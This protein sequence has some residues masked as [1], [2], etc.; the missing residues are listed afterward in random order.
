MAAVEKQASVGTRESCLGNI[1]PNGN[2]H[3]GFSADAAILPREAR[4]SSLSNEQE[5]GQI[6]LWYEDN[7]ASSIGRETAHAYAQHFQS[8]ARELLNERMASSPEKAFLK[9]YEQFYQK[10]LGPLVAGWAV[11]ALKTFQG[12]QREVDPQAKLWWLPRDAYPGMWAAKVLSPS[13]GLSPSVN[14]EAHVNRLNLGI[15]DEIDLATNQPVDKTPDDYR[16]VADYVRQRIGKSKTIVVADSFQYGYMVDALMKG[17]NSFI[18]Q[19]GNVGALWQN[20]SMPKEVSN[21]IVGKDVVLLPIGF[22]SHLCGGEFGDAVPS[23]LNYLAMSLGH[24]L[25]ASTSIKLY[26]EALADIMEA[27]ICSHNSA[28]TFSAMP[29]GQIVPEIKPTDPLAIEF[30]RAAQTGITLAASSYRE[31]LERSDWETFI[32]GQQNHLSHAISEFDKAK[33]GKKSDFVPVTAPALSKREELFAHVRQNPD[34]LGVS[35]LAPRVWKP[36]FLS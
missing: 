23:Y 21:G 11:M 17:N 29:D 34:W 10:V 18:A 8:G 9:T 26:L 14:E 31:V 5:L 12:I 25:L 28:R 19:A 20:G 16:Q 4:E 1:V 2:N 22:Y 30:A 33:Q 7:T 3:N 27:T 32:N 36:G 6:G 15:K 13:L 35:H 24:D